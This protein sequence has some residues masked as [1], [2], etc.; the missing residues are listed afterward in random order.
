MFMTITRLFVATLFVVTSSV[1]LL[2]TPDRSRYRTYR[3]GEHLL[4]IAKQIGVA[5][6]LATPMPDALSLQKLTWRAQYIRHGTVS[7]ADPVARLVFSFYND[8]LFRIVIDYARERTDG[9]TEGDMVNAISGIYG[10]P[11]KRTYFSSP[12]GVPPEGGVSTL[13]ALWM[14]EGHYVA[15]LGVESGAAAFRMIVASSGLDDLARAAG[16][17][18]VPMSE[19]VTSSDILRTDAN[20]G[21]VR[22]AR[23]KTRQANIA[24]FVP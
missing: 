16:A 21:N 6:P 18:G 2:G 3:I 11:S 14:D 13:I 24:S 8:Q 20:K 7:P 22:L 17:D 5:P 19:E 9:M 10:R 4:S 15:L 12:A 23:E 1:P